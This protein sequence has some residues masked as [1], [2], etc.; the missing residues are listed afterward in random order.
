MIGCMQ[1]DLPV[2]LS[3]GEREVVQALDAEHGL[4]DAVASEAAVAEDFPTLHAGE[5][6][7]CC[8]DREGWPGWWFRRLDG[9]RHPCDCWDGQTRHHLSGRTPPR[10]HPHLD[11]T[12]TRETEPSR[13]DEGRTRG[14]EGHQEDHRRKHHA[15]GAGHGDPAVPQRRDQPVRP[16]AGR[17]RQRRCGRCRTGRARHDDAPDRRRSGSATS[18]PS[19]TSPPSG[20]TPPAERPHGCLDIRAR[21][22]ARRSELRA[23]GGVEDLPGHPASVVGGEEGHHVGHVLGAA[24]P[25][26]GGE[27]GRGS[28]GGLVAA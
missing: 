6:V 10:R 1:V 17:S 22:R 3:S 15:Q 16:H 13:G 5:G 12:L 11:L 23:S 26:E 21:L 20:T 9:R 14:R 19:T 7:L 28:F 2:C 8:S 24:H 4:M 27:L 25:A 18:P